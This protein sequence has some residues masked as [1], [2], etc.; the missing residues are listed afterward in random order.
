[1]NAFKMP[2]K[3]WQGFTC[4]RAS[5]PHCRMASGPLNVNPALFLPH[6]HVV[7]SVTLSHQ[8]VPL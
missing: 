3:S 7:Q 4:R 8:V 5:G 1:M 2:Y 6:C